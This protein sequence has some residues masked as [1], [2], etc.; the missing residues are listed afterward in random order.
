[1]SFSILKQSGIAHIETMIA[2]QYALMTDTPIKTSSID[3]IA[4]H[5]DQLK[6]GNTLPIGSVEFI[7][8]AMG[9]IGIKEPD[10]LSYPDALAPYLHRQVS[11][12]RAGNVIGNWFIKPVTTKT[13]TGFVFDT[14]KN[15]ETLDCHDRIQ[16][17]EFLSLHPNTEVWISEPVKWLSEVR[18][19]LIGDKI[20]GFG[21]YDDGPDEA[22]E[23]DLGTVNAMAKAMAASNGAP[24]AFTLDV[25]VLDSGETALIE[26]NDAWSIGFYKGTLSR[27]GYIEMLWERW[28]QLARA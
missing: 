7:R 22:P 21:R 24:A 12:R 15:P 13:F 14:M 20:L 27:N 3:S 6:Q 26:C 18:Y 25:G 11:R 9:I 28:K 17:N 2:T 5:A 8:K 23:P 19:Y 4:D 16:Y 1:V 10:N